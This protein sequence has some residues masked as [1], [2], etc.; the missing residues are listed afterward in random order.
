MSI[1]PYVYV[2]SHK[3]TKEIYIGARCANKVPA[4][5]DLGTYYFTSSKLVKPRFHEFNW[6]IL[7]EGSKEEVFQFESDLITEHWRKPYLL[8]RGNR[9][10]KFNNKGGHSLSQETKRKMRKPKS[11]ETKR[12]MRKSKKKITCPYCGKQG[13][14]NNMTRWHFENCKNK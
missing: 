1:Y 2:C 3:I 13:S 11:E 8:N 6:E 14:P 12:K 4:N 10:A 7:F 5:Q 9:G